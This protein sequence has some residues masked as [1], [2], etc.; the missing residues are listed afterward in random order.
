MR[1]VVDDEELLRRRQ[2][3]GLRVKEL[4]GP[5]TQE[6]LAEHAGLGPRQIQRIESGNP[7]SP[8]DT[9][10]R[11]ALALDVDVTELLKEPAPHITRTLG[12]PPKHGV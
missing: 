12:R 5:M 3:L 6:R 4:R 2:L 7:K 11:I 9:L 10:F 1:A 8:I